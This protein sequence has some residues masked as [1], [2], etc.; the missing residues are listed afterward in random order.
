MGG[1]PKALIPF[2]GRPLIAHIAE[3]LGTV[4]P[5]RLVVTS[6]PEPYA[7][8]GLPTVPDDFAEGG[9]LGGIYSGLRAASGDAALVVACDMP[10]LSG[11]L[12]AYLAGRAGEADVV[13][14][15]GGGELQT[16][17]AVYAKACLPA[18]ARR[19]RAGEL[20]VIG[21]FPDV[22]VLRVPA[23]VVGRFADPDVVFTNVNTPAD[24]VRAR[25]RW[26]RR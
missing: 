25:A 1:T 3:T 21:F 14:P 17:H 22:R 26:A 19:L 12:L 5:D 6:T 7:F 10:F 15:E 23:A 18:M 4:L 8:L 24:L 2:E 20:R 13:V 9:A 11:E 16:L